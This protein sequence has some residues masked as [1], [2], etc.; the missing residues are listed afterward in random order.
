MPGLP[1]T[2]AKPR[3]NTQQTRRFDPWGPLTDGSFPRSHYTVGGGPPKIIDL[4]QLA[5][6]GIEAR[7]G[8]NALLD[9]RANLQV[10]LVGLV[11]R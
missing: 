9:K 10:E 3:C 5:R 8:S 2:I 7:V 1:E 11:L 6:R 4:V